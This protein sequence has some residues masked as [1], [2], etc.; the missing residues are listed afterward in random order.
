M[1]FVKS[2]FLVK[3]AKEFLHWIEFLV[4]Y[5][6]G[7]IG[8]RL[9]SKFYELLFKRTCKF[10]MGT[11]IFF[12][13]K[14]NI[15]FSGKVYIGRNSFFSA[16]G[17]SITIDDNCRFNVNVHINASAG[18]KIILGRDCLIGPNV[19]MRT[20]NHSFASTE[21]PIVSQ[22]HDSGDIIIE[23]DVWLGS[24]VVILPGVRIGKGAVIGA[25][26]VVT[27][28]IPSMAV[29]VGVPAKIIKYRI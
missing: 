29:A 6:P 3:I 28:D 18:G 24:N 13:S 15:V 8:F 2:F 21:V 7:F 22:G 20:A 12:S 16:E 1:R 23:N 26:S 14:E 10:A 5:M 17:G 4:S 11:G 25:T 19:V 9:R 27:K